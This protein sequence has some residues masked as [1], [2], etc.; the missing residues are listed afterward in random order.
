VIE[1]QRLAERGLL[2]SVLASTDVDVAQID[3]DDREQFLAQMGARL[4]K[5]LNAWRS[6]RDARLEYGDEPDAVQIERATL[7]D[8]LVRFI[9]DYTYSSSPELLHGS[10]LLV[11]ALG[12]GPSDLTKELPDLP[13]AA[14]VAPLAV[15]LMP[16][17]EALALE[18]LNQAAPCA[19]PEEETRVFFAAA[20]TI[21][22]IILD[23]DVRRTDDHQKRDEDWAAAV[24]RTI[25]REFGM[26]PKRA[27]DLLSFK[28]KRAA[29]RTSP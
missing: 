26:N 29:R 21:F 25:C 11:V 3:A 28:E 19:D 22:D 16:S 2:R 18:L 10:M 12:S 1:A 14:G 15:L 9:A 13:R 23:A 5:P 7:V 20:E 24:L 4:E 8:R 6:Q 17:N 27:K